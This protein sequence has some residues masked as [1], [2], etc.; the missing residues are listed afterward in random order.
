M[1]RQVT[2]QNHWRTSAAIVCVGQSQHPGRFE[3]ELRPGVDFRRRLTSE[4]PLRIWQM[5]KTNGRGRRKDSQASTFRFLRSKCRAEQSLP[6]L[7]RAFITSERMNNFGASA[8]VPSPRKNWSPDSHRG[9]RLQ[10]EWIAA[11]LTAECFW[12]AICPLIMWLEDRV[13]FGFGQALPGPIE[14]E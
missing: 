3:W 5:D 6:E 7:S 4:V 1:P 8:P 9:S 10:I 14:S 2:D 13:R 11:G 12:N